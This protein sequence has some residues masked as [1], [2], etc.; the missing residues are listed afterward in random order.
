MRITEPSNSNPP[1]NVINTKNRY[2]IRGFMEGPP[3]NV[4]EE[5]SGSDSNSV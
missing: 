3:A 1:Y 5:A 2:S 4:S